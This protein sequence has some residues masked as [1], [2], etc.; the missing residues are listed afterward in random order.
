VRFN[1]KG[2]QVKFMLVFGSVM[3]LA[4]VVCCW[5]VMSYQEA[6]RS[7]E[8]CENCQWFMASVKPHPDVRLAE[9]LSN[10]MK[11]VV[12]R[13]PPRGC[14]G[15][16]DSR[17]IQDAASQ[18]QGPLPVRVW[19]SR[20]P[21][22]DQAILDEVADVYKLDDKSRRLMY[23]IYLVENGAPGREMGVLNNSAQ[24]FRGH[25]E[26]SL[27]L[28]A[29]WAAGTIRKCYTGNLESFAKRWCPVGATNDPD[30]L[31]RNWLP[32]ARKIMAEME[33]S[34]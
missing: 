6:R 30:G 26:K 1:R 28:Q 7:L 34:V 10:H 11:L 8:Q 23:V 25:H 16:D 27:R 17:L 14:E 5:M 20:M 32:N 3:F 29:M 4:G 12:D 31:N 24:R 22:R 21:Q 15:K 9:Y 2:Q 18:Q 19:D 13:E 33:S